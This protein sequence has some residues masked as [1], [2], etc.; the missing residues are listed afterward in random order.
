MVRTF[1]CNQMLSLEG[2]DACTTVCLVGTLLHPAAKPIARLFSEETT[3]MVCFLLY[4]LPARRS[5]LKI[6]FSRE[7]NQ[8]AIAACRACFLSG[9][10]EK[11]NL[12]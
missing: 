8:L 3:I 6:T 4:I 2:G 7:Y 11:F 10:V 9:L 12:C 1:I 5:V